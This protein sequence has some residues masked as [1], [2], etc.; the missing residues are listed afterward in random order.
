MAFDPTSASRILVPLGA[1]AAL[2]VAIGVWL[3]PSSVL[4]PNPPDVGKI[5]A[6][7]PEPPV[8]EHQQIPDRKQW[9]EVA[10]EMESLREPDATKPEEE[11]PKQPPGPNGDGNRPT[12]PPPRVTVAWEYHGC[13]VLPGGVAALI[14]VGGNQRFVFEGDAVEDPTLP[15]GI[16]AVVSEVMPDYLVVQIEGGEQR[17]ERS[18]MASPVRAPTTPRRRPPTR[19]TPRRR[20]S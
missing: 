14:G 9:F 1:L 3:V 5:D 12:P 7:I 11:T 4:D 19:N 16:N 18:E 2:A 6:A 15:S 8:V 10:Q 13:V 17:I 20:R